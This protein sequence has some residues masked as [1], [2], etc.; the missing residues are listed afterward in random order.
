MKNDTAYGV[1]NKDAQWVVK[2]QYRSIFRLSDSTFVVKRV[3]TGVVNGAEEE[4]IP[5]EYES[6]EE[7]NNGLLRLERED[8]MYYFHLSEMRFI[9]PKQ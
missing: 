2:P 5:F 4:L 9:R 3:K 6:I 8:E 1:I 7:L